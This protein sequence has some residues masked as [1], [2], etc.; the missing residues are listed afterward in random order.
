MT[1]APSARF[2]SGHL[3][4]ALDVLGCQV[5]VVSLNSSSLAD[6]LG[7]GVLQVGKAARVQVDGVE[8]LAAALH[9]E[10]LSP[11]PAG[12]AVRLG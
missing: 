8:I 5:E 9:P 7:G 4:Q 12:T 1:C 3:S 2:P 10:R 6:V 11:P